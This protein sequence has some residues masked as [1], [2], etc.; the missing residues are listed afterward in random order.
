L[1][2]G[3]RLARSAAA[4]AGG[5][6]GSIADYG[7]HVSSPVGRWLKFGD[8]NATLRI[9]LVRSRSTKERDLPTRCGKTDTTSGRNT[10][11]FSRPI[12]TRNIKPVLS[13]HSRT[14]V[15]RGI[16]EQIVKV[17]F[18]H[19]IAIDAVTMRGMEVRNL[20]R[21]K[22]SIAALIYVGPVSKNVLPCARMPI[23]K[24]AE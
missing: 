17:I 15:S 3:A 4:G 8:S 11:L 9:L 14:T 16:I 1:A 20:Q 12:N 2:V 24:Q 7:A 13:T 21:M 5:A 22:Q 23:G 19:D 18:S 6:G 10:S